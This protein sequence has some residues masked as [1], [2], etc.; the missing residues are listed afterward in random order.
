MISKLRSISVNYYKR[1]EAIVLVFDWAS[2]DSF[3]N[4]DYW[5]KQIDKN[6]PKDVI[7]VIVAKHISILCK[8]I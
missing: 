4:V 3:E 1:A 5:I 6:A 7:K 8:I 2:R